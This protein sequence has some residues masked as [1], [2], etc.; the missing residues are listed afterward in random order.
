[1]LISAWRDKLFYRWVNDDKY[2]Y[3]KITHYTVQLDDPI[4]IQNLL[5]E[6]QQ[7]FFF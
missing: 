5:H 3:M 4:E 6:P 7:V 1:M 2:K